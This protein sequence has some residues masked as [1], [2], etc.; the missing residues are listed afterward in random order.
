MYECFCCGERAVIWD[1]D[2]D[3]EARG[4]EFPG[5]VHIL[6]CSNCGAQIEY[7]VRTDEEE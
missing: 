3:A 1:A 6:H 4:Y 7:V 5:I 2:F